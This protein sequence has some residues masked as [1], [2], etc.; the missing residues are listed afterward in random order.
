MG[1][2]AKGVSLC[3]SLWE[4]DEADAQGVPHSA[5]FCE[6]LLVAVRL[7]LWVMRS[8]ERFITSHLSL[9]CFFFQAKGL[10]RTPQTFFPLCHWTNCFQFLNPKS[11]RGCSLTIPSGQQGGLVTFT[12]SLPSTFEWACWPLLYIL[13]FFNSSGGIL[14]CFPLGGKT[15]LTLNGD[16]RPS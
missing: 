8:R 1:N 2:A 5:V 16:Y 9:Y 4:G 14:T 13:V 3:W 6:H 7:H 15:E 11:V 12:P 10:L